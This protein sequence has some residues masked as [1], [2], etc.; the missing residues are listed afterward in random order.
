MAGDQVPFSCIKEETRDN[1]FAILP[2]V[3]LIGKARTMLRAERSISAAFQA[4]QTVRPFNNLHLAPS[5]VRALE[6]GRVAQ[7]AFASPFFETPTFRSLWEQSARGLPD[8]TAGFA[9]ARSNFWKSVNAGTTAEAREA[10]NILRQAGYQLQ[11]VDRAP[12]L[13]MRTFDPRATRELSD[14]RLTIDHIR[15]QSLNPQGVLDS[16][17]VRFM[18]ARD[19]AFRGNRFGAD[20]RLRIPTAR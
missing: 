8:T 11:S 12:L 16:R 20:D 7:K 9:K 14:L 1:L 19:N 18:S 13:N 5:A 4:W 15:P 10:G 3:G 2:V 6:D 17:N